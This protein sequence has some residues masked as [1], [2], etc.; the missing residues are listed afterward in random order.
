MSLQ[1]SEAHSGS[2]ALRVITQTATI[3]PP[4]GTGVLDTTTGYVF[5]GAFDMNHP[6][7]P[8]IDRP[9]AME[10]WVKGTVNSTAYIIAKL[11]RRNPT[12]HVQDQIGNAIYA[13]TTSVATYTK[14]SIPFHY[15]LPDTPDTLELSI[16]AGDAGQ[17][18]NIMP[19]NELFVDDIAFTNTT[20]TENMEK[21]ISEISIYPNP[22]KNILYITSSGLNIEY[23][24]YNVLGKLLNSGNTNDNAIDISELSNGFYFTKMKIGNQIKTFK[25]VKS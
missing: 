15:D 22:S 3:L 4:L 5:L 17:T 6:G 1:T 11:H 2:S 23:E 25:F 8:Y 10:A 13:M 24:I 7:I 16:M 12:T 20:G 21:S 14:V 18:K 9:A 19:G